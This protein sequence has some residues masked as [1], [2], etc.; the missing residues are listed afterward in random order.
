MPVRS[1]AANA[2]HRFPLS[3]LLQ[4]RDL[5]EVLDAQ[6]GCLLRETSATTF[7]VSDLGTSCLH[8]SLRKLFFQLR[9]GF[10]A[11]LIRLINPLA[12]LIRTGI[13]RSGSRL[14]KLAAKQDEEKH[15]GNRHPEGG[16]GQER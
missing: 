13:E 10:K 7:L 12:D 8:C 15:K 5:L 11:E 4:L 1:I 3:S 2:V 9:L 6:I 16:I 14:P